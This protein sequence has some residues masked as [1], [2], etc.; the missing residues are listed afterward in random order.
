MIG[1]WWN[2]PTRGRSGWCRVVK[3]VPATPKMTARSIAS[4][5]GATGT[6]RRPAACGSGLRS[7]SQ[8]N[9]QGC[10]L[11]YQCSPAVAAILQQ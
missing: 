3:Y 6:A 11:D 2:N 7:E 4:T 10:G 8:R 5:D 1:G 9:Q